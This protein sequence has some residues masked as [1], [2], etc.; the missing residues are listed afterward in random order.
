MKQLLKSCVIAI[1]AACAAQ[2]ANPP[3]TAYHGRWIE[4]SGDPTTLGAVDAAFESMQSSS[5]M[6]CLP[7]LYKRDWDG[8]VEGPPWPCWWIQNSFG[9]SYAMMPF[10]GEPYATWMEHSQGMWFRL[11][12]DGQRKDLNGFQGPDGCLCDAAYFHLNGGS[13]RGF[14]DPRQNGGAVGQELDGKIHS[15]GSWYRQGDGNPQ[16]HDWFIGATAGGLI[17]ESERLLVRHDRTAAKRRLPELE[18]VAAFLDSRRD[19]E[20]NLLKGAMAA[21]LLAPAYSGVRQA[22]GTYAQAYLTELSV[23]YIAGIERLAEVCILSGAPARA[24]HYHHIAAKVRAALPR[25]MTPDGCFIMSE[26]PD[27]TRHGIYGAAKHGYFE[28]TPNHDAGCFGVT[29]DGANHHIMKRMLTLKGQTAPGNLAPH[30]L[31]I[32]NYPGYDDSV[33]GGPYGHWVNGGHWTTTQA[34]MSIACLRANEFSHPFGAWAKI[35]TLMEGYRADAPLTGFGA[36]PWGDKLAAPYC[37]V[38]DC[39]GAPG[40]L[41][42]GLFEYDYRADCLRVRPHLPADITRYVQKFPVFFGKTK[43]Y[44][45]VTGA[46][47]SVW[48]ELHP[49]G[50]AE[51]LAIEI[52]RGGAKP[53]G[54]WKPSADAPPAFPKDPEFWA[55]PTNAWPPPTSGNNNPLRI[56]ASP[57]GGYLF[58][59]EI[60]DVRIYRRPLSEAE[61]TTLSKGGTVDGALLSEPPSSHTPPQLQAK[62]IEKFR[63]YPPSADIDFQENFTL[64]AVI[65]PATLSGSAR[66]ID[67]T[68][69][70]TSDG[71][72]LDYLNDGKVLRL[73][74][75][76][77]IAQGPAHLTPGKRQHVAATCSRDG[78]LRVYLDGVRIAEEQ[79]KK[80]DTPPTP[81]S[82]EIDMAKIA[83]FYR[84]LCAA[85]LQDTYEAAQ[86]RTALE[87]F[88]AGK[89]R[90][91]T[92]PPLPDL[93]A[94]NACDP[95][96]VETLYRNTAAFIA[97]GLLDRLNGRHLW[98]EKVAPAILDI[99]KKSG[100]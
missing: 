36:T 12:G 54:A 20:T 42:R 92:K 58:D 16:Q 66:L 31:I 67:R 29:D 89:T 62:R 57:S 86:A 11:M 55:F 70:G 91:Q 27:G 99:A 71:Y 85:G 15:Q 65:I 78:V 34:R 18:R 1:S 59:G 96:A 68:T 80:P 73:L 10:L 13:S 35:R 84:A 49:G 43:I 44:L 8:F 60:R 23:N 50:K 28:S 26:D 69:V 90:M 47:E 48:T 33:H 72:L 93:G 25:M 63:E 14:G 46:G 24:E 21:N 79:G 37:V 4:G 88:V 3:P 61:I 5:K 2:A 52:V 6:A 45:T 81:A 74:T 95:Q 51:T 39:W 17:L 98:Q 87:L 30:G 53:Q 94:I 64:A 97:G 32:P 38:Y 100:L 77:G 56:G 75:P 9:P 19:P 41:L 82:P 22:D 40:G 76:W 83:R 7:L